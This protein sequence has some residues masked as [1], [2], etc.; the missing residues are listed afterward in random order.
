MVMVQK[1]APEGVEATIL[2][3]M[4]SLWNMTTESI[5]EWIGASLNHNFVGMTAEKTELY[6]YL[7]Y[8]QMGT[9]FASFAIIHLIPVQADLADYASYFEQ[10]NE[11]EKENDPD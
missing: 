6:K 8:I 5:P 11:N 9:Q 10:E 4:F 3:T 2:A 7:L 1:L